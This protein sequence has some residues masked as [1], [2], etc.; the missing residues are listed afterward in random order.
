MTTAVFHHPSSLQHDTGIGHPERVER[1]Q[2]V[3]RALRSIEGLEWREA[4]SAT[5]E[6]IMRVHTSAL[7][8][9]I[10]V[11]GEGALDAD[12][13]LSEPS[14]TAA[15]HA[16]GAVCAAVEAVHAGQIKNAFCAV[17]PP[18]HH[19]EPDQ[20]MGFCLFNNIAVGARQAQALG[21][22]R[23]AVLGFDVHHGNGTQT[24]AWNDA[25]FFFASSHQW[26]HYPGTGAHSERGAYGQI[27][28]APLPE[29]CGSGPFRA[30]W[31][32]ELLPALEGFAPDFIFMSA[33]FDAHL[34][35]P[36][37][38][39][40]LTTAD[41]SWLTAQISQIAAKSCAGRVVS[42]LEGGYNLAALADS[43]VAHVRAL[44]ECP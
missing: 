15:L 29:G 37:G 25:N 2:V 41:F 4:P 7:Y 30:V 44:L 43:T 38:G 31:Q 13:V 11:F 8:D 40:G 26:P 1:V 10:S 19:A 16:A 18:G 5:P 24:A 33:G 21:Y 22:P 27:H 35:D 32:N 20:A 34:A 14:F 3:W 28:N 12:T 39:L 36:L 23:V 17:R 9:M 42:R 6:Q